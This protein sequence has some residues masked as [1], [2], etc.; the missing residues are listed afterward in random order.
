MILNGIECVDKYDNLFKGKRIGLITSP[1]GIDYNFNST[2]SI[3]HKKYGL[4]A[5]FSPEHGVLGNAEA[6]ALVDTYKDRYTGIPV[7]SLYRKDSK[8]LTEVML[9]TVDIVVYDI[10][11]VGV[12]Y[13]T[14]ISTMLYAME[15]C[16]KYG[17]EFAVMDRINPLDGVTV[18]G[19]IL[20][21]DF[22]SFVGAF[23]L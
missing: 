20:K 14:F 2:I 23:P 10:Q 7:Y 5:I 4:A 22:R 15:D 17:K 16:T 1:S 11:D 3:L 8:R 6:G 12:R 13:Y 21:K 9:S 18:E 19:N